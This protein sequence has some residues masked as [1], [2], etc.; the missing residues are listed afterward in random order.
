[1]LF[2]QDAGSRLGHMWYMLM[3]IGVYIVIPLINYIVLHVRKRDLFIIV[4][5]QCRQFK[6]VKGYV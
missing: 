4:L 5:F 2:F 1:M 6:M 3:I